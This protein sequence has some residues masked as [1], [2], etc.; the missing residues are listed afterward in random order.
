MPCEFPGDPTLL[1]GRTYRDGDQNAHPNEHGHQTANAN[2]YS[3]ETTHADEHGHGEASPHQ[4]TPRR[5][6]RRPPIR[7]P[8]SLLPT[9]TSTLFPAANQYQPLLLGPT[10][11]GHRYP[12]AGAQRHSYQAAP[13]HG[14]G[15]GSH[16]HTAAGTAGLIQDTE[17]NPS[18]DAFVTKSK[19]WQNFGGDATLEVSSSPMTRSCLRF[20][21]PDGKNRHPESENPPLSSRTAQGTASALY[22]VRTNRWTEYK[23]VFQNAPAIRRMIAT[24]NGAAGTWITIDLTGRLPDDGRFT[25]R[26]SPKTARPSALVARIGEL[27]P[28]LAIVTGQ[29]N[30]TDDD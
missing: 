18:A 28:V 16:S 6:P 3:N 22:T 27:A 2:Q 29:G 10:A 21:L 12:A 5:S 19:K 24:G 23:I 9:K 11:N 30:A 20:N 15:S 4:H 13:T 1:P 26:W 17:L 25:W 8:L 14:D 7:R